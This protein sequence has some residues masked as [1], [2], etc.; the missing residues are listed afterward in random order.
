LVA[1][2]RVFLKLRTS[3][4]PEGVETSCFNDF[5]FWAWPEP[6]CP[7]R[8]ITFLWLASTFLTWLWLLEWR[9]QFSESTDGRHHQEMTNPW[10][11]HATTVPMSRSI[12]WVM[13]TLSARGW[14]CGTRVSGSDAHKVSAECGLEGKETQ[15]GP[16]RIAW[17]KPPK[18]SE[19]WKKRSSFL[20]F[21]MA[22]DTT[23]WRKIETSKKRSFVTLIALLE[24]VRSFNRIH[25]L[26]TKFHAWEPW[27]TP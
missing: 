12:L 2:N 13:L 15:T 18:A 9:L 7:S 24:I 26:I 5:L 4:K 21:L 22:D 25:G 27:T 19:M 14:Y 20:R 6:E 17:G 11:V 8:P 16:E 1:R 23:I 3:Q 10:S